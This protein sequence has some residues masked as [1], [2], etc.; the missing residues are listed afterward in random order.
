M[1]TQQP[2]ATLRLRDSDWVRRTF[3]LSSEKMSEAM[4]SWRVFSTV[5]QKYTSARLGCNHAINPA[6]QFTRFADIRQSG[7]IADQDASGN[8]NDLG[9]GRYY[10]ESLDD[11]KPLITMR[12]G[13]PEYNGM[14]SYFTGFY[15]QDAAS[16]AREGRG[17]IT[18]ALTTLLHFAGKIAATVV[19]LP[20]LHWIIIGSLAKQVLGT[21]SSKYYYMKQSMGTYWR[22]VQFIANVLAINIGLVPKTYLFEPHQ[23]MVQ[24]LSDINKDDINQDVAEQAAWAH[25]AAPKIFRKNGGIDIFE[26]ANQVQRLAIIR[27]IAL[28]KILEQSNSKEQSAADLKRFMKTKVAYPPSS[29]GFDGYI[30]RYHKSSFGNMANAREEFLMNNLSQS[31]SG[32]AQL[33]PG[34][35]GATPGQPQAPGQVPATPTSNTPVTQ[36]AGQT[37]NNP[38]PIEKREAPTKSNVIKSSDGK[39]VTTENIYSDGTVIKEV[40]TT[41]NGMVTKTVSVTRPKI[42]NTTAPV[43]GQTIP[44]AAPGTPLPTVA[45]DGSTGATGTGDAV[46]D[47]ANQAAV[48]TAK[49]STMKDR[50][51]LTEVGEGIWERTKNYLAKDNAFTDFIAD[52]MD[53]SQWVTF[54]VDNPGEVN[55]SF[56]N[57]VGESAIANTMNSASSSAASTRFS[58][59]DGASGIDILDGTVKAIREGAATFLSGMYGGVLLQLAGNALVDIPKHWQSSSASMP[60][61][62]YTMQLR[63]VYGNP[64]SRFTNIYV[65]LAMLLAAALPISTGRQSYTA[66]YLCEIYS[67]GLSQC[68]LGMIT[69]LSIRRG[70]GNLGFNSDNEMLGL[71]VS[72]TVTDMSTVLHAPIETQWNPIM[73]WKNV[74]DDDNSFNDYMSILGNVSMA[75]AMYPTHQLARNLTRKRLVADS[76]FSLS[77]TINDFANGNGIISGRTL[78]NLMPSGER[79][80]F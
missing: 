42:N 22:R 4:L 2:N 10:S 69:E 13:T 30:D 9:M 75:D 44:Q 57:S 6:P 19:T 65:P 25:R 68:R 31:I 70:T 54:R 67:Q 14:L 16:L 77:R 11:H 64:L 51:F 66:P 48:A 46:K 18:G 40:A 60:S 58:L 7:V 28:A 49:R 45:P 24:K 62:S 36:S 5:N 76:Y 74:F 33:A 8:S 63:S 20:F 78:V 3:M 61:M 27:R 17:G 53:G 73:P 55:E 79:L 56:T 43:S 23:S 29:Q 41:N 1:P 21:P 38:V 32:G 71:D 37:T 50:W 12:F 26:V 39:V 52:E 35:S 59:S 80:D 15:D 34:A 47:A 72:F